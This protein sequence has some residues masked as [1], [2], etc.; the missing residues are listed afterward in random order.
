[1]SKRTSPKRR[2]RQLNRLAKRRQRSELICKAILLGVPADKAT[3]VTI[4][5]MA[6]GR[7]KFELN[8]LIQEHTCQKK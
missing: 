1:M 4:H 8:H 6:M 2:I 7:I 5:G 3:A